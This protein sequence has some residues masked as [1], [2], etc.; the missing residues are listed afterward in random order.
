[1]H[2]RRHELPLQTI[3]SKIYKITRKTVENPFD[4]R[5]NKNAFYRM[6]GGTASSRIESVSGNGVGNAD[7]TLRPAVPPIFNRRVSR[8][9]NRDL[10]IHFHIL[11]FKHYMGGPI[12]RV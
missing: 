7:A 4:V 8:I 10:L 6:V 2:A 1:M 9:H 3:H 12:Y 11:S 5:M